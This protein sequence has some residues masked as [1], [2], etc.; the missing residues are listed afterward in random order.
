M[1]TS[2]I[3]RRAAVAVPTTTVRRVVDSIVTHGRVRR[4]YLG[5][6]VQFVALPE[7]LARATGQT[8][9]LLVA[10]VEPGS[11]AADAGVTLGDVLLAFDGNALDGPRRLVE[12]LTEQAVGRAVPLRVARGGVV[13]ELQV[14]VATRA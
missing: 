4:G 8:G 3:L 12:L 9:G 5:V 10:S 7:A 13:Q 1:N 14:T 2:G 11:A 6:G